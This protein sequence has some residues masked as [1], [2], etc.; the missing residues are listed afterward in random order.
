MTI[1]IDTDI[2]TKYGL[3][4]AVIINQVR[5]W[6]SGSRTDEYK[7]HD[8]RYW[9]YKTY[10]EW[11][12]ELPF[13]PV[14]TLK[15]LL[16]SMVDRNLILTGNYSTGSHHKT[17]W[18]AVNEEVLCQ[19]GTILWC[20]NGT[21]VSPLIYNN[22]IENLTYTTYTINGSSKMIPLFNKYLT[23]Y[24]DFMKKYLD[25]EGT[26]HPKIHD[27]ALCL[28]LGKVDT[29]AHEHP[30]FMDDYHDYIDGYFS[31]SFPE[32]CDYHFQHF[33]TEGVLL[34]LRASISGGG[35]DVWQEFNEYIRQA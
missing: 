33:C 21:I 8:G 15:R 35:H 5:Y 24:R 3:E 11:H 7:F 20:Q 6:T 2:A 28:C 10:D 9:V 29:F 26:K 19:N 18:Y 23:V 4:E 1:T 14:R 12:R 17:K 34:R 31:T 30:D 32:G 27:D 22:N 13:I 25:H 16:T